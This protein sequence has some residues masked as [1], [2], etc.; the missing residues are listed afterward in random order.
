L[1]KPTGVVV[2]VEPGSGEA[3]LDR[4][5]TGDLEGD[6]GGVRAGV[7]AGDC[8]GDLAGDLGGLAA[9]FGDLPALD[10]EL[11]AAAA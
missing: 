8:A 5:R 2:E 9:D 7:R 10:S 11:S 3:L 4:P 6:R 1:W